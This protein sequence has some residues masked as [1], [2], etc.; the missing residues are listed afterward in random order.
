MAGPVPVNGYRSKTDAV[1]ALK[2]QGL[3]NEE[4]AYR[5]CITKSSVAGLLCSSARRR[6]AS[7][8]ERRTEFDGAGISFQRETLL[9][10]APA[11]AARRIHVNELVRRLIKTIADDGMVDGVLDDLQ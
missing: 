2:A 10:L 9:K 3:K 4:I 5:L 1:L 7:R 11:A 8:A 6:P